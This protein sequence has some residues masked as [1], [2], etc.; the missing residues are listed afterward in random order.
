MPGSGA[1]AAVCVAPQ[2]AAAAGR[3]RRA[4]LGAGLAPAGPG[5]RG[6]RQ[7]RRGNGT[8]VATA[9]RCQEATVYQPYPQAYPPEGPGGPPQPAEPPRPV[10]TAVTLMYVGAALSAVSFILTLVTVGSLRSAV[11]A[12]APGLSPAQVNAAVT[13]GLVF[14]GFFGLLG[15]ALWLWMAWANRRGR[16]WARVTSTVFFGLDTLGLLA[17]IARPHTIVGLLLT[18]LIWLAGLGAIILLWGRESSAYFQAVSSARQL[19]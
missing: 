6:G 8:V 4:G 15:I 5:H 2:A 7:Q 17:A 1:P 13:L 14:V 3:V 12:S 9:S 19:R 16:N 10:R 11:R 18:L